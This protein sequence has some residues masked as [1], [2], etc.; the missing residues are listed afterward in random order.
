[1][2]TL[3]FK[4]ANVPDDEADEVRQ[5]LRDNE[6]YFYETNAGM[7]K[8]GL[9]AIWL[10][11]DSQK[12]QAKA[13]LEDYQKTRTAH[14][15]QAYAELEARG[16]APTFAQKVAAHPVRFLAQLLAII[17]ILAISIVP[18]WFAFS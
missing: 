6:I 4:L 9:D 13:L 1:M 5:L 2:A 12:E 3:L 18:F 8:V 14:Q 10:P 7:W 16:E 11:D 15:Q 17:F